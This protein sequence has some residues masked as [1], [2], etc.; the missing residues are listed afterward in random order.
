M[1]RGKVSSFKE[2][3]LR[4][5]MAL[6]DLIIKMVVVFGFLGFIASKITGKPLGELLKDIYEF[7][8]IEREK[9]E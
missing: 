2:K 8:N 3:K 4:W 7:F 5:K 1:E 9:D 6:L